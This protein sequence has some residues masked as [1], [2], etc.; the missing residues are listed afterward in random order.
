MLNLLTSIP[1]GPGTEAA[2]GVGA[3]VAGVYAALILRPAALSVC[4]GRGPEGIAAS[5]IGFARDP[6]MRG[7]GGRTPLGE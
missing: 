7:A 3:P 1:L 6:P 5:R 4:H 2:D